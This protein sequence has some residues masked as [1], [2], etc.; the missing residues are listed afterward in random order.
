[1]QTLNKVLKMTTN[2]NLTNMHLFDEYG[3]IKKYMSAESIIEEWYNKMQILPI[4]KNLNMRDA[5]K[6][7]V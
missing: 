4:K 7:R 5:F 6:Q 1:M 3:N 2:L